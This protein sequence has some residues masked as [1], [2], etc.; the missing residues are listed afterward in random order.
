MMM[1]VLCQSE[2]LTNNK[3]SWRPQCEHADTHKELQQ[4]DRIK[5]KPK[6]PTSKYIQKSCCRDLSQEC[7]GLN[8]L[9]YGIRDIPDCI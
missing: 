1:T 8:F 7:R 9:V 3:P 5:N 2:N 6:D 4:Q